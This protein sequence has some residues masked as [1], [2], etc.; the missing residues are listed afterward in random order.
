MATVGKALWRVA[1]HNVALQR[2]FCTFSALDLRVRPVQAALHRIS[3][4]IGGAP[5]A[6]AMRHMSSRADVINPK[7]EKTGANEAKEATLRS[8]GAFGGGGGCGTAAPTMTTKLEQKAIEELDDMSIVDDVSFR[9]RI[10]TQGPAH[11]GKRTRSQVHAHM[12]F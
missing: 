2:T 7:K 1:S 11:A 6:A 9:T 8:P 3:C 10:R 12:H 5:A 4:S